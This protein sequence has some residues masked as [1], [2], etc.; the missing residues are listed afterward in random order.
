MKDAASQTGQKGAS[1]EKPPSAQRTAVVLTGATGFLGREL[2]FT[3]MRELPLTTDIVCLIRA[4]AKAAGRGVRGVGGGLSTDAA[5]LQAEIQWRL[6]D[7][8][9]KSAPPD[10][11]ATDPRRKRVLAQPGDI[12]R[13]RLGLSAKDFAALAERTT[14]IYHGAATVRFDLPLDEA[15]LTNVEGT[16]E[17]LNLASAAHAAGV[18]RRLHYIGTAFVAGTRRGSIHEEE[19]IRHQDP[20]KNQAFNNTYEETKYEA[21]VLVRERMAAGLP[22]T[23]YRP[24]I[25]VGDSHSGYTSSFKV[26][27]WPLKVFA[28]GLIPVV[29][30]ARASIVDLVPVDFVVGAIWALGQRSDSLGKSYH[31]AAGPEHSTTIGEAMEIAAAFFHVYKPLFLPLPTYER[32][33]RPVLNLVLRGKRRRALEAGRVYVPYLNYSA[34]FDTTNARRDLRESGLLVPDVRTYFET[35][36]RYCVESNWG[37]RK[38]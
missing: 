8:L 21:E 25:V 5:A 13:P 3:F 18:L 31:L 17:M 16:R 28:R 24:S 35:L 37:K 10:L 23:I 7:L 22:V 15:R 33:V 32:Y 11:P 12:I 30:A 4:D 6:Q 1:D 27:Y 2:L 34:S 20:E 19:L 14:D 26:M 38:V 29:P 36:L 9:D